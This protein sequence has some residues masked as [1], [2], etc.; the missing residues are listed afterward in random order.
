MFRRTYTKQTRVHPV[1]HYRNLRCRPASN[2]GAATLFAHRF[3]TQA[4]HAIH[5][6]SQLAWC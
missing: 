2:I 1:K 3:V 6:W 4:P 5:L